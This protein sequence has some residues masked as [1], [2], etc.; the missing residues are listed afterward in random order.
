MKYVLL[1]VVSSWMGQTFNLKR[2]PAV[3][4]AEFGTLAACQMAGEAMKTIARQSQIEDPIVA[5]ACMPK[6]EPGKP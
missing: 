3:A 1:I 6:G 4:T 2:T 5:T